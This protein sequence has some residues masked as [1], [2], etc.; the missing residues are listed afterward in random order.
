MYQS[1]RPEGRNTL[2]P[3]SALLYEPDDGEGNLG[4]S[5]TFSTISLDYLCQRFH[6]IQPLKFPIHLHIGIEEVGHL[7]DFFFHPSRPLSLSPLPLRFLL[8][9]VGVDFP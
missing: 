6:V 3:I 2:T 7:V 9:E 4:G 8:R 5:R 1:F